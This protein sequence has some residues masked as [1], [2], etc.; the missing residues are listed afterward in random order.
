MQNTHLSHRNMTQKCVLAALLGVNLCLNELFAQTAVA[1]A[2]TTAE[3]TIETGTKAE[4]KTQIL[5]EIMG[6]ASPE[7][8][9]VDRE[10]IFV[11][12]VGQT[13]TPLAKDSD[14]FISKLDRNGTM[15]QS[16][17]ISG[18]HAPKGMAVIKNVL[19]VVDID[20]LK[21]FEIETKRVV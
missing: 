18:L 16:H 11:S 6:F 7:S 21:A 17:F 1:K 20:R 12:N 15:I 5:Q 2:K 10:F 13:L 8:V 19:F 3:T 9:Y 14:G 4:T